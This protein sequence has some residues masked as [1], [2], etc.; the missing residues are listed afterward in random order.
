MK[1]ILLTFIL[2]LFACGVIY[3]QDLNNG[4]SADAKTAKVIPEVKN[5]NDSL[6]VVKETFTD[7]DTEE[8]VPLM[9]KSAEATADQ[10]FSDNVI[11][12]GSLGVGF[13]MGIGYNFGY[14]T[15]VLKENQLRILFDDTSIGTFPSNDWGLIA[16]DIDSDGANYF[17]I[18]DVTAGRNPFV[19]EAGA[20]S[21]SLYI[22]DSGD[23]GFG[24]TEPVLDLHILC[25]D[26]P[27]IRC[28]QSG[29][30]GW[31]PQTWDVAGNEA[32]FFIRDVTNGSKLPFRIEPG[33]STNT[34]TLKQG[35]KVGIGNWSPEAELHVTGDIKVEGVV[36]FDPIDT[37]AVAQTTGT[38]AMDS[39][40]NE[41]MYYNGSEWISVADKQEISLANNQLSI[42][43]SDTTV[44]LASFLD[45]TDS[46]QLNLTSN[47]LSIEDGNSVSLA[48]YVNTDEQII[49]LAD[50]IL[51]IS[52]S[53]PSVDLSEYLD[54]TDVQEISLSENT[55]SITGSET[56][57]DLSGLLDNTDEQMIS[58]SDNALTI[59]G[60]ETSVDL[61]EYLD[62]TDVQE[63]SF[64]ENT[65]SISGSE[66]SVDLSEYLDN[67]D[68]QAISFSE[69]T[70][71]ITGSETSV[72]FSSYLDNTDEQILALNGNT[73]S[74]SDGNSVDLSS[75]LEEQQNDIFELN[76]QVEDLTQ[77]LADLRELMEVVAE[78]VGAKVMA[79]A[80]SID[81]NLPNPF[82]TSTVIP[83][84]ITEYIK[85]AYIAFYNQR[86]QLIEKV[87]INERGEGSYSFSHDSSSQVYFYS[88]IVDGVKVD[89]KKMIS[90]R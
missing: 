73:L 85:S 81:Q 21:N 79:K 6:A 76:T 33:A 57:V 3:S 28:E 13:D 36:L 72:D 82:S 45:N 56:S 75:L 89:S 42:T 71:S 32:N 68:E 31:S 16:N 46:Q 84:K 11:I 30:S 26:T 19:V 55:L 58:L 4:R 38:M 23:V 74:I 64:S 7:S 41:M 59:S 18:R 47:T 43:G 62:N 39:T 14:N 61:S 2:P 52:G 65:L 20:F 25:S 29:A 69:N 87:E 5:N 77:E 54:N 49:L 10:V 37:S 78:T 80:C 8:E 34:L 60:S 88:L 67:T 44:S 63:I 22:E 27:G 1:K 90:V 40:T 51:S 70:L 9:L 35:G 24:T 15:F 17:A 50:N 48:K 83:Y 12:T 86:G 66:T 53:E